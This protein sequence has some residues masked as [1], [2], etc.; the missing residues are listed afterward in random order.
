MVYIIP[1]IIHFRLSNHF[2]VFR[3]CSGGYTIYFPQNNIFFFFLN[4]NPSATLMKGIYHVVFALNAKRK[5]YACKIYSIFRFS[6]YRN[7]HNFRNNAR[8]ELILI[9]N[10]IKCPL[11]MWWGYFQHTKPN[12]L[13]T[14]SKSYEQVSDDDP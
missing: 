8:V 2:K 5:A 13:V 10:Y 11:R 1:I 4:T 6:Q 9:L 7:S 3:K 14:D 12:T